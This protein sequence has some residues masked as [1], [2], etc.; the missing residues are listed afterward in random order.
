M[1]ILP[2]P[3]LHLRAVINITTTL[4]TK[5]TVVDPRF[6]RHGTSTYYMAIFSYNLHEIEE[7]WAERKGH[8]L[9]PPSQ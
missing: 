7:I 8:P 1:K 2:C 9:L 6:A 3:K 5:I 4:Y